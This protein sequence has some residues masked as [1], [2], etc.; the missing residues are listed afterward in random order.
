MHIGIDLGGT[1]VA[2]GLVSDDAKIIATASTSTKSER[3]YKH[4]AN[5]LL[6]V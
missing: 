3:D 5:I 1:N 6:Q 2:V 4:T